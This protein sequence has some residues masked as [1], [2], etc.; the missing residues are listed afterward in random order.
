MRVGRRWT[1]AGSAGIALMAVAGC[2]AGENIDVTNDA[3]EDV[4]VRFA[5]DQQRTV[6]AGGGMALLDATDC[7]GPPVVVTYADDRTVEVDDAICPGDLLAVTDAGARVVPAAE[8]PDQ[9]D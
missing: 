5:D 3:A 9:Q 6:S 2:A 7:Y 4:D 8:R 1:A